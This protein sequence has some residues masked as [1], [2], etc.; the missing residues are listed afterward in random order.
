MTTPTETQSKTNGKAQFSSPHLTAAR[1][2]LSSIEGQTSGAGSDP[3]LAA[4]AA[5][6]HSFLVLAEQVAAARVLMF[7]EHSKAGN[8]DSAN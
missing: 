3:Q 1:E 2:L 4:S 7:A 8:G 5:I 6:A